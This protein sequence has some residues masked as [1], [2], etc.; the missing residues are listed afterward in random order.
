MTLRELMPLLTEIDKDP[1]TVAQRDSLSAAIAAVDVDG[2]GEIDFDEFLQLM[3]RFL[4]DS[5]AAQ[6]LK[7]KD[8]V[9]RSRFSPEDVAE[10]RNIFLKFD[11]DGSGSFDVDEGK[12][13]LRA[14]GV[15]LND[16]AMAEEYTR[17]FNQVDEDGDN[18]MDFPEFLLLMRVII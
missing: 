11:D 7:E 2:G 5:D 15:N 13:L 10:W 9:K 6:L 1:K 8:C 17:L 16:R 14:V 12:S 18:N 4:D 3:R